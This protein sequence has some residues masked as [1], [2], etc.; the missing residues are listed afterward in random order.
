MCWGD[1]ERSWAGW[2]QVGEC[3]EGRFAMFEKKWE[4]WAFVI[5]AAVFLLAFILP[6][7]R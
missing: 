5:V 4:G 2:G 7:V 3:E 6:G 1:W